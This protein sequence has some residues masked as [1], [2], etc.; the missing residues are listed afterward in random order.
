MGSIPSGGLPPLSPNNS[1]NVLG[2]NVS[3]FSSPLGS[4][5]TINPSLL[6]S[7]SSLDT[8]SGVS[9]IA[10]VK[11]VGDV[12]ELLR[13][14][15][16]SAILQNTTITSAF[17]LAAARDAAT[18]LNEYEAVIT[19]VFTWNTLIEANGQN[20][21][22]QFPTLSAPR[23][24]FNNLV[25]N[26]MNN[27]AYII[28]LYNYQGI[29]GNSNWIN[30]YLSIYKNPALFD[31][32]ATGNFPGVGATPAARLADSR[33]KA[34]NFLNSNVIGF[35]NGWFSGSRPNMQNALNNYNTTIGNYNGLVADENNRIATVN[36][37]R[38][39]LGMP[40]LSTL[41]STATPSSNI[42]SYLTYESAI[43][44]SL[45]IL[46]LPANSTP[47]NYLTVFPNS[48]NV[49]SVPPL[50]PPLLPDQQ[51]PRA[52][53]VEAMEFLFIP[54]ITDL[55]NAVFSMTRMV[56]LFQ[57]QA[58]REVDFFKGKNMDITVSN[59][60]K[61]QE[62]NSTSSGAGIGLSGFAMG[63]QTKNLQ[64]A[65]AYSLL[66]TTA[67]NDQ[68]PIADRLFAQ[69]EFSAVQLLSNSAL[70]SAIPAMKS[71]AAA[72]GYMTSA[73]ASIQV[74]VSL[75]ILEQVG[76]VLENGGLRSVVNVLMN[77][78][79]QYA[80]L[81]AGAAS[82]LV[83]QSENILKDAIAS[84]NGSKIEGAVN[85]LANARVIASR[86]QQLLKIFGGDSVGS[87]G[88][89]TNAT[90]TAMAL[91]MLGVGV[92]L[93]G[94]SIGIPDLPAQLFANASG[95][96]VAELLGLMAAGGTI[97]DLLDNPLGIAALKEQLIAVLTGKGISQ[98][99]AADLINSALG[100]VIAN[101]GVQGLGNLRTA[102][103]EAF[104]SVLNPVQA[105]NLANQAATLLF[106]NLGFPYSN[107]VFS[108]R[109]P[110]SQILS[111][112]AN[113][114]KIGTTEMQALL[115][116]S[117][118]NVGTDFQSQ[119]QF[120]DALYRDLLSAQLSPNNAMYVANGV[121]TFALTG[122]IPSAYDVSAN[123]LNAVE[124][125]TRN[126]LEAE[127][128]L[129]KEEA[130][131]AYRLAKEATLAKGPFNTIDQFNLVMMEELNKATNGVVAAEIYKSALAQADTNH[132]LVK[133]DIL[134]DIVKNKALDILEPNVGRRV[135][136]EIAHKIIVALF[137]VGSLNESAK[138]EK[139][140]PLSAISRAEKALNDLKKDLED[141]DLRQA[142]EQIAELLA[143]WTK[144]SAQLGFLLQSLM[145][146]PSTFI[147]S[148]LGA[149]KPKG[150]FLEIPV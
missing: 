40:P 128:G 106:G 91:S 74:A 141:K 105:N 14:A 60:Y 109:Y 5:D 66:K 136:E 150:E 24:S 31:S 13:E 148:V 70:M 103:S 97:T 48:S 138:E 87:I 61:G 110:V 52:P 89:F 29:N 132:L 35:Y 122:S 93:I 86:A 80:R 96:P 116:R 9:L 26:T 84:G 118:K 124:K 94:S 120:R 47:I 11:A 53:L 49:V 133:E 143:V 71:L 41:Q 117:L 2:S 149:Q 23:D 88:A 65:L 75:S 15:L 102:L 34:L 42:N 3:S 81:R 123:Y 99:L 137:G 127:A 63:L 114:T 67:T 45:P 58:D 50:T 78:L 28:N 147:G 37:E 83:F 56:D 85:A 115:E 8:S 33:Q 16:H 27:D 145:D 55:M 19:K 7:S 59:A 76:H 111:T 51:P 125:L 129:S 108:I 32:W 82:E 146:K 79:P 18:V 142:N 21:I 139:R 69:L 20:V 64:A 95:A 130:V 4:P 57:A 107:A 22:D 39:D 90:S 100:Q 112:L 1:G 38:Q 140:D 46:G 135:A 54:F 101:G 113:N 73:T 119:G 62:T 6:L 10:I 72:L 30:G 77:Q 121:A 17:M 144:P 134:K 98:G 12:R 25:Y 104:A 36:Q 131:K 43:P 44:H 92:A 68:K 126:K